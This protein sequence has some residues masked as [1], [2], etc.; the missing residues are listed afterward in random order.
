[1]EKDL[2]GVGE[3]TLNLL[4]HLFEIDNKNHYYLFYNSRQNVENII[5]KFPQKNIHYCPFKIPNKLLNLSLKLFKYPKLDNLIQKKY[6]TQNINQFF[7][8]NISFASTNCP[9]LITAHD[10][11]FEIFPEFLSLKR[12]LWHRII[13]PKKQYQNAKKIIAVSENTKN[14]L[15]KTFNISSEKIT[16]IYSGITKN[17]RILPVG[18]PGLKKIKRKYNLPEKFFLFLGTIE[19]RK[20]LETLIDAFALFQSEDLEKYSLV[21]VGKP[22]WKYKKTFQ[23]IEQYNSTHENK[24]ILTNFIKSTE[25]V[26]FYN[27]ATLFIYPSFYEGFG[28]P[29]LEAMAC[30]CPV[31]TSP[32]SS[33]TE[34]CG[35]AALFVDPANAN[36]IKNGI[37]TILEN[38][39]LFIPQGLLNSSSFSWQKSA[40]SFLDA[41]KFSNSTSNSSK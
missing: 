25:K 3:Y 10:L 8:P 35:N 13:N 16:T 34:I 15:T 30:G 1:M 29:P 21:I 41:L 9:Y 38:K 27:L 33:L 22:G 39:N 37:Q 4:T 40:Q 36:E 20:N 5:P 6:K 7:F 24:I 2:T 31:I 14:D 17:F 26:F 12:K 32:N 28:F 19:P 11:S 23:K 18:H